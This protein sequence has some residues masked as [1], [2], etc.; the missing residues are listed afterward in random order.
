MNN[1]LLCSVA[2]AA[3]AALVGCGDT[4]AAASQEIHPRKAAFA[5]SA[6][7]PALN[8]GEARLSNFVPF[9]AVYE[10]TYRNAQGEA[11]R[12][13]VI[14]TAE[15]VAWNETAAISVTLIDAGNTEYD[16]TAM[17]VQTR[18]F[19][20]DDHRLLLYIAPAPGSARDYIIAHTDGTARAALVEAAGKARVE[21]DNFPLPQLGAPGPWLLG[22]MSLRADQKIAFSNAHVPAPSS[23]LGVRPFVVSG[24][25]RVD[26]GPLGTRNAWVVVYPLGMTNA[27]VMHNFVIDRPPYL[28]GKRPMDLDSGETTDVGTLRLVAFTAFGEGRR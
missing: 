3:G 5:D 12:D 16:D 22:S 4:K 28:V 7:W 15:R 21:T 2:L 11:R 25:E 9:R 18:V 24:Q 14:I 10:R 20:E 13:H 23:I 17:R 27:R 1:T 6:S 19:A 26:A 8:V